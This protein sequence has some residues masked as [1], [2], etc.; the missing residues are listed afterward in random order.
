MRLFYALWPDA[1]T[2]AALVAAVARA[3]CRYAGKPTRAETLH[4]TLCF[5][6]EVDAAGAHRAIAAAAS[7]RLPAFTMRF[8]RLACWRHNRIAHLA[9]SQ[10]PPALLDLAGS[11]AGAAR[12]AD[13][14]SERRPYFPHVTLLRKANCEHAASGDRGA[15]GVNGA[16]GVV[17]RVVRRVTEASAHEDP[18]PEP[19]LWTARDFVLVKSSLRPEGARYEQL[20]RW[21]LL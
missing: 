9:M 14:P 12:A 1:G 19:L 13:L 18:A 15:A 10:P 16:A 17:G 4:L 11:L 2:R 7:P 20:G 3:Q 21:P 6:G 5:L 8:D